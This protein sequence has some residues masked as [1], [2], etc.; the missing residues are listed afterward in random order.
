MKIFAE[1]QKK[2]KSEN[3][4]QII[5]DLILCY[6]EALYK[7]EHLENFAPQ[8]IIYDY[9]IELEDLKFFYNL[10]ETNFSGAD[11]K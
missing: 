2:Q 7:I 1:E 6:Y 11:S 3:F 10:I 8:L 5:V 4:Y 9:L